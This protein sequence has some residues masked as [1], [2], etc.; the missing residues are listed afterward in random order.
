MAFDWYG[1]VI[2][3]DVSSKE[4]IP[5]NSGLGFKTITDIAVFNGNLYITSK[6]EG[7]F[8]YD[9]IGDQWKNCTPFG[10]HKDSNFFA[11][12]A[13]AG[14]LVAS[15][16]QG[17]LYYTENGIHW[18]KVSTN[19][20]SCITA[21]CFINDSWWFGGD[22]STMFKYDKTFNTK[23]DI[24]NLPIRGRAYWGFW[25]IEKFQDNIY[26]INDEESIIVSKDSG[27][28]WQTITKE[29]PWINAG[30]FYPIDDRLY[31]YEYSSG[32]YLLNDKHEFQ[33]VFTDLIKEPKER[34]YLRVI[35][36]HNGIQIFCSSERIIV[37]H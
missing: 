31:I 27:T 1:G 8:M 13:D 29:K 25:N 4:L 2:E 28:T 21:I 20:E 23:Q 33:A 24:N 17:Y 36:E 15:G 7:I 10:I 19:F 11:L 18:N 22:N 26:A 6:V 16:C 5:H 30:K 14:I 37:I 34:E 12:E 35:I 3:Y 9:S 32:L